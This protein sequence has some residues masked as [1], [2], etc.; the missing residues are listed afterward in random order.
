MPL[1]GRIVAL[2]EA[3]V[4][5]TDF[6]PR[7]PRE[8]SLPPPQGR[9]AR[10]EQ[11]AEDA[12]RIAR[13]SADYVR[14]LDRRLHSAAEAHARVLAPLPLEQAS[15]PAVGPN[16][17]TGAGA[18]ESMRPVGAHGAAGSAAQAGEAKV[19]E[20]LEASIAAAAKEA[21][22]DAV[23]QISAETSNDGR[24]GRGASCSA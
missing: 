2:R 16:A 12:L 4:D 3:V 23:K 18:S 5:D 9:Q 8:V 11:W 19:P 20:G 10:A 21:V 7:A 15:G 1:N 6:S 24:P 13:A 14:D 22:A 17:S